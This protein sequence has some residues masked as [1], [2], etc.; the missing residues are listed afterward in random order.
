MRIFISYNHSD[1]KFVSLLESSLKEKSIDYFLD[2]KSISYG[3]SISKSIN[4]AFSS[5]THLVVV[6]SP[7]SDKSHWVSFEIG[8]ALG[9]GLKVIPILTHPSMELPD[10]IKDLKYFKSKE[11]FDLHFHKLSLNTLNIEVTISLIHCQDL[12]LINKS[13]KGQV[14]FREFE[15][16][17][18]DKEKMEDEA[19]EPA[20]IIDIINKTGRIL[21]LKS[22]MVKFKKPQEGIL[23]DSSISAIGF[24]P[25]TNKELVAGGKIQY[26]HFSDMCIGSV[27]ALINNNIKCI[28]IESVDG[29]Q[30]EIDPN[31]MLDQ[32]KY[33]EKFFSHL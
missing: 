8:M 25:Y 13:L 16:Q 22:P 3:E 29:F 5:V 28:T 15:M 17:D 26:A 10:F 24:M 7:G 23:N 19:W 2:E 12:G 18:W 31:I 20:F 30:Y 32:K 14:G 1:E 6:I 4:D 27:R 21:E 9:K 33:A 11:E